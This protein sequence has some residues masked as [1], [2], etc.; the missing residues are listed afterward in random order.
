[1]T[2]FD[3]SRSYFLKATKRLKV[4]DVLIQEEAY[5][6]VIREAQ[7][8]V[9]LALKGALRLLGVEPPKIHDVGPLLVE[10]R[11]RFPKPVA[12]NTP[13]LARISKLPRREHELSFYGDIDL[14]P[15]EEYTAEDGRRAARDARNVVVQIGTVFENS[16]P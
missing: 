8:I 4:L 15:K 1:V 16:A 7:E 13:E 2:S 3:L 12:Q 14:I 10:N 11:D 9:E 6:D 5:S